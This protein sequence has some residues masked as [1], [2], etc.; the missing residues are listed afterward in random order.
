M[1]KFLI[2]L[3]LA[4]PALTFVSCSDDND[5][6]DV[7]FDMTFENATVVD[8]T[9]YVVQG[10]QFKV[11]SI[12]VTNNETDK[13]AALTAANY[14]WDYLYVGT[15][16]QPPYTFEFE[17]A[18][19]MPVGRHILEVEG[20]LIALDKSPAFAVISNDVMVVASADD[21]PEA[22]GPAKI[23]AKASVSDTS[24]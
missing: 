7:D 12:T 21:I 17:V 4:I 2:L 10:Q 18:E 3:S 1:K 5:L 11:S 20:T 9:L 14:Y 23:H 15:S 22:T 19:T 6:P 8:G 13:P 24:K 16:V